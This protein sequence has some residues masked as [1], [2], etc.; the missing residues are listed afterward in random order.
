MKKT[1]QLFLAL[2]VAAFSIVGCN[3]SDSADSDAAD[4]GAADNQEV[5][6]EAILQ[7]LNSAVTETSTTGSARFVVKGDSLTVTIDVKDAPADI[8]HWQHFHGFADG[9]SADV[10]TQ[11]QDANGDG[12][13]DVTETES[14]SGTTMVPFNAVPSNMDVGDDS[15]PKADTDGNYKYTVTIPL[16][17]LKESFSKEFNDDS[18]SLDKRVLFIHGVPSET[19]LAS[20]VASIADIPAQVTIPIAAGKINKVD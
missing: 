17:Q 11:D 20:S 15:Y 9:K 14:V 6:Y 13:I 5:V 12:I 10:P 1:N 8:T 4:N 3:S 2:A 19:K 16:S 7:P 18:L